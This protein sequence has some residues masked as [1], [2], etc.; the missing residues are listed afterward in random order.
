MTDVGSLFV[1]EVASIFKQYHSVKF[2]VVDIGQ[3]PVT[4]LRNTQH[5]VFGSDVIHA[6]RDISVSLAMTHRML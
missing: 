5:I 6:T 1:T 2:E 4:S 3:E